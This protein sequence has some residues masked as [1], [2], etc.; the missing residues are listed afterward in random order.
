MTKISQLITL[1]KKT[2]ILKIFYSKYCH[3]LDKKADFTLNNYKI[4]IS[5]V[6]VMR[7]KTGPFSIPLPVLKSAPSRIPHFTEVPSSHI[8]PNPQ[9]GL[10]WHSSAFS[11]T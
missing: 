9:E 11:N 6:C 8:P 2:S 10:K 1:I 5:D 3:I 4:S 7:V